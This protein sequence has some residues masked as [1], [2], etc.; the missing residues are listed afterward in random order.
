MLSLANVFDEGDLLAFADQR[1]L[2]LA[3]GRVGGAPRQ[4]QQRQRT[5]SADQL[6]HSH[7][8]TP[9]VRSP[10]TSPSMNPRNV[11]PQLKL[12]QIAIGMVPSP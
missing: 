2:A 11:N 8:N 6:G 4:T 7:P 1:D 5:D 3:G 10:L 12:Y 9:A